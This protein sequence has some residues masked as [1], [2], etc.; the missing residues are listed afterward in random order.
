MLKAVLHHRLFTLSLCI[1]LAFT[2]GCQQ[3]PKHNRTPGEAVRIDCTERGIYKVSGEDLAGQGIDLKTIDLKNMA[4]VHYQTVVPFYGDGLDDGRFDPQDALY[5]FSD[6]PFQDT[7]PYVNIEQDFAPHAQRFMLHLGPSEYTPAHFKSVSAGGPAS[8]DPKNYGV[9]TASGRVHFEQ[10]P[11]FRFVD[12][13]DS[14]DP[15][16]VTANPGTD[17]I[18]WAQMTYPPTDKTTSLAAVGFDLPQADLAREMTLKTKFYS[19]TDSA[20]GEIDHHVAV[21]LNGHAIGEIRWS[22]GRAHE[23]ELKIPAGICQASNRLEYRLLE[24]KAAFAAAPLT[25]G[26]PA[27]AAIDQVMLDWFELAFKQP[28]Q[29]CLDSI[30]LTAGDAADQAALARFAIEGFTSNVIRVFDLGARE[31]LRVR[32]YKQQN[33]MYGFNLARKGQAGPLVAVTEAGVGNPLALKRVKTRA[34]FTK[35]KDCELLILTHPAFTRE[36]APLVAWKRSRGLKTELVEIP[37]LFNEQSGGYAEPAALRQYIEH[38]YKS[39]PAGRRLRYV[40]LVGDAVSLAKYKSFCPDYAYLQCGHHANENYF[41]AFDTPSGTPQVALGRISANDP[42][43]VHNAVAKIIAVESGKQTGGWQVKFLTVAAAAAWAEDNAHELIDRFIKPNF[44]SSHIQTNFAT[45]D[46]GLQDR[47]TQDLM[48]R[49]NDGNL[50]TVF[51]GHGGGSVWEVGPTRVVE[52]FQRHLFDQS[53][54]AQLTNN[55]RLPLV[56]AMTCYTNDFD[57]PTVRQTLGET[58]VNSPAGAVAVIGASGRSSTALNSDLIKRLFQAMRERRGT[59]LGDYFL[60]TL[61][62]INSPYANINYLLLGD[63]SL[64]FGFPA[65]DIELKIINADRATGRL[66]FQYVLP[67][68]VALPAQ[69]ELTLIDDK[70]QTSDEL[71]VEAPALKGET[72]LGL[73]KERITASMR[74]V[75]YVKGKGQAGHSCSIPLFFRDPENKVGQAPGK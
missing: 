42:Q 60:D 71:K 52:N 37:D 33:S 72:T 75:A 36:L 23:G 1:A 47:M 50:V 5:F 69:L 4:L 46:P 38:I 30:E 62:S 22:Q 74:I 63:P 53:S 55:E 21:A 26:A 13:S 59:R 15:T 9:R 24:P 2:A 32:P 49:F 48:Q 54:V 25:A 3:E 8:A 34:L 35:P 12:T 27:R 73:N 51:F 57:N 18:F 17:F 56:C 61:K 68:E 14:V 29:A 7:I 28:T 66:Q 43:Q 67:P 10:D 6:G 19:A 65:F 58:F 44:V 41:A 20:V 16:T 70:E 45:R 64:E 11:I 31:M 40:L 39:Q